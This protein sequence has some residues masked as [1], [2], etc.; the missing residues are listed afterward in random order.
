MFADEAGSPIVHNY[1]S[2]KHDYIHAANTLWSPSARLPIRT[3]IQVDEDRFIV[4]NERGDVNILTDVTN[5]PVSITDCFRMTAA[6]PIF[7]FCSGLKWLLSVSDRSSISVVD[8]LRCSRLF[9]ANLG[10]VDISTL[11]SFRESPNLVGVL[12]GSLSIWDLRDYRDPT[13]TFP[14]RSEDILT[15]FQPLPYG[16][17]SMVASSIDGN[18]LQL[19]MRSP[20][21]IRNLAKYKA[22]SLDVCEWGP[23]V[24]MRGETLSVLDITSGIVSSVVD[25]IYPQRSALNAIPCSAFHKMKPT[26]GFVA[27]TNS[28][29]VVGVVG[30]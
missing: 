10:D 13:I 4:A 2:S 20:Q 11:R 25:A 12:S 19:D 6:K 30:A 23:M 15:D 5:R 26:L 17:M 9:T 22:S 27:N 1:S 28:L 7:E 21:Q 8:I 3:I 18:V 29:H 14:T 16:E 24:L